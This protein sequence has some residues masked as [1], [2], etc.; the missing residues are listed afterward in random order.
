MN[1][2]LQHSLPFA[3]ASVAVA[4]ALSFAAPASGDALKPTVASSA[5]STARAASHTV[6]VEARIAE[7]HAKLKITAAQE[8]KWSAVAQVM[9]ENAKK[10]DALAQAR[11]QNA[12]GMTAVEDVNAYSEFAEAHA[13]G[14]KKFAPAFASLY[15][16]MSDAQKKQADAL[17]Q[18]GHARMAGKAAAKNKS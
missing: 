13:E 17:F 8:D 16:A 7:M 15:D 2:P 14:L 11:M 4:L 18:Q 3:M 9:R 1:Q 6:R 12:K 10:L 5:P